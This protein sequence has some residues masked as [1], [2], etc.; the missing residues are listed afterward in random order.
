MRIATMFATLLLMITPAKAET[1]DA[2]AAVVNS[3]AITCYEVQQDVV[4]IA[5]QT[6]SGRSQTN[7]TAQPIDGS[8]SG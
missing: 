7:A 3:E 2:I 5:A 1:F 8:R 4:N 6:Y